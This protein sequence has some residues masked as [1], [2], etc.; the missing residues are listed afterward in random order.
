MGFCIGSVSNI[1]YQTVSY[2]RYACMNASARTHT[3]THTHTHTILL[4]YKLQLASIIEQVC[5]E[6]AL[7]IRGHSFRNLACLPNILT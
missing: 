5:G 7:A 2:H 4:T 3:H 6:V 1:Y